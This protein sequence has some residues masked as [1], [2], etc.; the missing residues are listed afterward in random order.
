MI[1]SY[2]TYIF[3]FSLSTAWS[4]VM[5]CI[6]FA[7]GKR[8]ISYFER[9]RAERSA[10]TREFIREFILAGATNGTKN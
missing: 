2:T 4:G 5:L 3:L 6:G 7:I 1:L 10:T 9:K 8:I